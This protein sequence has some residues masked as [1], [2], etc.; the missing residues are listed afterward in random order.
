MH[1]CRRLC[2]AETCISRIF[3]QID[4]DELAGYLNFLGYKCKK[5]EVNDMIWEGDEDCD[6]CV[7]WEEFKTMCVRL[8][9][10]RELLT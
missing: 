8:K 3:A 4:Q 7:N 9:C 10:V 1:T 2:T 5:D 6:K